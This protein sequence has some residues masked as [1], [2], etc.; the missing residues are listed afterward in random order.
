MVRVAPSGAP[1]KNEERYQMSENPYTNPYKQLKALGV[2]MD[3]HES[4]LYVQATP[5]AVSI[6]KAS[7]WSH[8]FFQSQIDGNTWIDVAFAY[9]PFWEKKQARCECRDPKWRVLL[10]RKSTRSW[11]RPVRA[12]GCRPHGDGAL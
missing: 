2:P 8:M 7:G 5:E 1:S 6:V 9:E 4:D 3:S 10:A 11:R 12:H